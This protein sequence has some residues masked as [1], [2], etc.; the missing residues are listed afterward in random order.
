MGLAADDLFTITRHAKVAQV[1]YA[2]AS[3]GI[4]DALVE[5]PLDA[6]AV[7]TSVGA[8]PG[9][10]ARLLRAAASAGV[11]DHDGRQYGLNEFSRQLCSEG[12]SSFRSMLL[13]WSLLRPGYVGLGYL[14]LV[15]R[16]GGSG[17]EAA[18]GQSWHDYLDTHPDDAAQYTTAM[19]STIDDFMDAATGYDFSQH[20]SV[21]DV[22]GGMG[23]F[24]VA[25][26]R[27]HPQVRGILLDLPRVVAGAPGFL[28]D[29]PE[30]ERIEVLDGDLFTA[31]P[32]GADAYMYSTVLRCFDDEPCVLALRAAA[33]AMAPGGRVLALEMVLEDGIPPLAA[34]LADLYAMT[35]YGGKDRT[36]AEWSALLAEA[37]F[38][39][40]IFYPV[41]DDY[42]IIEAGLKDI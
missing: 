21:V 36:R 30:G 13:G 2:L 6:P 37:G 24:L 1:V 34:G 10:V 35:V 31:V 11:L 17:V 32:S 5:G 3:L 40:P 42:V 12:E 27:A 16:D 19:E 41:N 4:P 23:G 33:A 7:A 20:A 39:E 14:D 22:G 28:A 18:F 8:I 29:F 26:I 9:R 15:V 38:D 25:I